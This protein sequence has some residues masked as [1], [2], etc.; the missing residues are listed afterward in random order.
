ML[1]N[2]IFRFNK[3]NEYLEEEEMK[4]KLNYEIQQIYNQI[5]TLSFYKGYKIIFDD[6]NMNIKLQSPEELFPLE[7]VGSKS[8]YMFMHLCFYLG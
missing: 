2:S 3:L 5:T 8:N 4:E 7:N 1:K 6:R